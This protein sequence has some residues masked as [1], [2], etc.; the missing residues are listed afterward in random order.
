MA[1]AI[2]DQ[3]HEDAIV[4]LAGPAHHPELA[5]RGCERAEIPTV[6]AARSVQ[7]GHRRLGLA[8]HEVSF[9]DR[10]QAVVRGRHLGGCQRQR[11]TRVP[12]RGAWLTRNKAQRRSVDRR[13]V[14]RPLQVDRGIPIARIEHQPAPRLTPR[15]ERQVLGDAR[16]ERGDFR[17]LRDRHAELLE[18]PG[19]AIGGAGAREREH[20]TVPQPQAGG[21]LLKAA[22]GQIDRLQQ[23]TPAFLPADGLQ[24]LGFR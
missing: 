9:G 5:P 3:L 20:A 6:P 2:H 24:P 13:V 1:V 17:L 4:D 18:Q 21:V 7:R 22:V 12:L 15:P 8:E 14:V 16:P 19:S 11:L 23:L 10:H